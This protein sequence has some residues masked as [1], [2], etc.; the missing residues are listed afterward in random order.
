MK[1]L[2]V[3]DSILGTPCY[4]TVLIYILIEHKIQ[5]V[6]KQVKQG[7]FVLLNSVYMYKLSTV[8]FKDF[9]TAVIYI[10]THTHTHFY[11]TFA[12]V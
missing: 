9:F 8:F 4:N 3:M 2:G 7:V 5:L 11:F 6:L 12:I 10:H 1:P